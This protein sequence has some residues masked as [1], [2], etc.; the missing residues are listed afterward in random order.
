MQSAS[1]FSNLSKI[2]NHKNKNELYIHP[3][4][5]NL[6][7]GDKTMDDISKLIKEAKP[8]YF[9]RKKR[10]NR[11]KAALCGLVLIFA[12]GSFYPQS[13][14]FDYDNLDNEIYTAENGSVIEDLGLPTDEYGLLMVS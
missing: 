2:I 11:I 1:I 7:M 3:F 14:H 8:L 9:A 5:Y 10:N 12:L 4:R 6:C 13:Y